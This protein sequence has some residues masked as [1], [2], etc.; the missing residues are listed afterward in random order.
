L[1]LASPV[2]LAAAT[3]LVACHDER[4]AVS[5]VDVPS[6]DQ[7]TV[8]TS[9]WAVARLPQAALPI[10][11]PL[12][13]ALSEQILRAVNL[14]PE[15]ISCGEA[16]RRELCV[17]LSPADAVIELSASEYDT[18]VRAELECAA[19]AGG[20]VAEQ[21]VRQ[22]R[23]LTREALVISA[24]KSCGTV[25]VETHGELDYAATAATADVALD[26]LLYRTPGA[27]AVL[28]APFADKAEVA[29]E[30]QPA[31]PDSVE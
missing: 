23:W 2:L 27:P 29:T 19:L 24:E 4:G 14:R 25:R 11:R 5:G 8:A 31:A 13:R 7:S 12:P 20:A 3:L 10:G 17:G 15:T 22:T 18:R 30:T 6:T 21:G 26:E 1:R 28:A 16:E 9:T